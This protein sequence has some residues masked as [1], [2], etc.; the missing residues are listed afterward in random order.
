MT[1][2][3]ELR[4]TG[5][6]GRVTGNQR[7]GARGRRAPVAGRDPINI[8]GRTT[9][10]L[11]AVHTVKDGRRPIAARPLPYVPTTASPLITLRRRWVAVMG[12]GGGAAIDAKRTGAV[13]PEVFAN[14][15]SPSDRFALQ[16]STPQFSD[17]VTVVGAGKRVMSF[18]VLYATDEENFA[19]PNLELQR[20]S[21]NMS[22]V[23]K[24]L[25]SELNALT[26]ASKNITII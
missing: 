10:A 15:A 9:T 18:S 16:T 2:K 22:L 8:Y 1:V 12:G 21:T 17:L 7:T 24:L 23:M 3:R 20:Y 4:R 14:A 19:K 26:H 6:P 25:V 13:R 5:R 11:A